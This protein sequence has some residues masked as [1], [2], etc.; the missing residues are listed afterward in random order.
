MNTSKQVDHEVHLAKARFH[1]NKKIDIAIQRLVD[2][3]AN[4]DV[5][6]VSIALYDLS[7]MLGK[8]NS[9]ISRGKL[10]NAIHS[11]LS[12]LPGGDC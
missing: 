8:A 5:H 1:L 9:S 7:G 10:L 2:S 6:A 3:N 12:L 11:I 4:V